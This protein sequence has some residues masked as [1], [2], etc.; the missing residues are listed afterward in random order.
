MFIFALIPAWIWKEYADSMRV[1]GRA[2]LEYHR[3]VPHTTL[4]SLRTRRQGRFGHD[5]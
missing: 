1:V 3:A 2:D 5:I 4:L